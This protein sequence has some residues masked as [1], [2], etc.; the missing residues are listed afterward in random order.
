M[1]PAMATDEHAVMKGN[2]Y[3]FNPEDASFMNPCCFSQTVAEEFSNK[4]GFERCNIGLTGK[5]LDIFSQ[6]SI[7]QD[8]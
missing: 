5:L 3:H 7:Y 8:V 1:K 2:C 4:D 6:F